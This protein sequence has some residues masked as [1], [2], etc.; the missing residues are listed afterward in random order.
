MLEM[1][2]RKDLHSSLRRAKLGVLT[3]IDLLP[4]DAKMDAAMALDKLCSI[5]ELE[6]EQSYFDG[7]NQRRDQQQASQIRAA[8]REVAAS[9]GA[10]Q[11]DKST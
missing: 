10:S 5:A 8:A 6:I 3:W 7:S 1:G 2:D 11:M 9:L 4:K